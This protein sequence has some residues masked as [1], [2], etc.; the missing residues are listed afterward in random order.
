MSLILQK[1]KSKLDQ[2]VDAFER[3]FIINTM[4]AQGWNRKKTAQ[5]LEIPI[6]TL[7]Y[8]MTRLG[9][10][11]VVPKGKSFSYRGS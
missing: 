2:A 4:R 11:G 5:E 9:I 7:K 1:E 3:A 6:S 8:K 10:Y